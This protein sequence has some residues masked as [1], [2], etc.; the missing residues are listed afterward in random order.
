MIKAPQRGRW[1]PGMGIA[2]SPIAEPRSVSRRLDLEIYVVHDSFSF[3]VIHSM[4]KWSINLA[5]DLR[6]VFTRRENVRALAAGTGTS[7]S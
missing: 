4:R 7:R 2:C 6:N 5:S 3:A 1:A